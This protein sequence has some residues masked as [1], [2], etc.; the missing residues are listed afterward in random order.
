[1]S[2]L[3][4]SLVLLALLSGCGSD[5]EPR[6]A[7]DQ[8]VDAAPV[9]R[10][11]LVQPMLFSGVSQ[12]AERADLAFQ[13][14]G[15]LRL[16]PVRI[17]DEVAPGDLLAALEN[18]DLEPAKQAAEATL[19]R[20]QTEQTQAQ[21]NVQRLQA[22][23]TEGAVGEQ[24][25]EEEQ[26]RLESLNDQIR[27]ARAQLLSDSGRVDDSRLSAP[28]GGL[29]GQVNFEVGEYVR[30]GETVLILGGLDVME[31]MLELPTAV[32][33][34][35]RENQPVPVDILGLGTATIGEV[36]DIG[37]L[38]DPLTGLFPVVVRYPGVAQARAGQRVSVQ[39]E[40]RRPDVMQVP[41]SAIVDPIGGAPRVYRVQQGTAV[42][43]VVE[44]I[45]FAG[46]QVAIQVSAGSQLEAGDQVIT[47]GHMSLVNGQRI[48]LRAPSDG[49]LAQQH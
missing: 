38:A 35:L 28:F 44:V 6:K 40:Q 43:T 9:V 10:A 26:T 15:V 17:G 23:F 48:N 32:W 46:T 49:A 2:R 37:A 13:S 25:L 21:R 18:P 7:T 20:L 30:A 12:A 31:V 24:T 41:L 36:Y 3:L 8:L 14:S 27:Q 39:F 4:L 42:S 22:L 11:D 19:A 33:K 29:I 47:A 45:G 16:R 1:M 34:D 5:S